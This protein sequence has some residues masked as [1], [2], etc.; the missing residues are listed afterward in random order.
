MLGRRWAQ[1]S[2]DWLTI[3]SSSLTLA[4]AA[5]TAL[6]DVDEYQFEGP[7]AEQASPVLPLE[8]EDAGK[9][10]LSPPRVLDPSGDAGS[11]M[12]G[13]GGLPVAQ[14]AGSP[15]GSGGGAAPPEL[16]RPVVVADPPGALVALAGN[17]TGGQPRT[18]ICAGGVLGGLF[19]QYFTSDAGNPDRLSYV[20][21]LCNT[22]EAGAPNLVDGDGYD[23]T[24]PDGLAGDPVF[25]AL[26]ENESFDSVTCPLDQY[27]V[28]IRGSFEATG[29]SVAFRSL[30]LACAPLSSNP[31]QS[32]VVPGAIAIVPAEGIAPALG[33]MPFEQMC[34]PGTT[35]SQLDLRFGNWLDAVGLRCSAVRW[36]FTAGHTCS[37]GEQCQSGS[38]PAATV[39][40]P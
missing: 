26:R 28:G 17:P 5:C 34:P 35:A 4:L 1:G 27:I 36:P 25:T 23:A 10:A 38:C 6:I 9:P 12:P 18:A 8:P 7:E 20:W 15:V 2:R 11:G 22:L 33:V 21:P 13:Q 39:C 30:S 16:P 19:F 37:S 32:D 14:D 40:A 29:G 24:F 31:E 3:S